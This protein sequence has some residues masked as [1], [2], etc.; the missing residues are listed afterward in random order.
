MP[1]PRRGKDQHR[2]RGTR[3]DAQPQSKPVVRRR[4]RVQCRVAAHRH[5]PPD[6]HRPTDP[7]HEE[8]QAD[9]NRD[10]GDGESRQAAHHHMAELVG[11]DLHEQ[12]RGQQADADRGRRQVGRSRR[13]QRDARDEAVERAG[14]EHQ[15]RVRLMLRQTGTTQ[16][17]RTVE[18]RRQGCS[19]RDPRATTQTAHHDRGIQAVERDRY[20]ILL[21]ED[22][23]T[24]S[25]QRPEQARD[26]Q[27]ADD[28]ADPPDPCPAPSTRRT[29]LGA[30][31]L[32]LAGPGRRRQPLRELARGH[33]ARRFQSAEQR[34]TRDVDRH[35]RWLTGQAACRVVIARFRHRDHDPT[36][37]HKP[38]RRHHHHQHANTERDQLRPRD[39]PHP[40][41]RPDHDALPPDRA[42]PTKAI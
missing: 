24:P 8:P 21:D 36:R 16:R 10:L 28:Q 20:P 4:R 1:P 25:P 39:R 23:R 22:T 7:P 29:R 18:T 17:R 27:P 37:I 34:G 38:D 33:V 9:P 30:G 26:S 2:H 6:D 14:Q 42:R 11:H 12:Q 5:G 41:T 31:V 40:P 35:G 15:P 32:V 3:R 13:R 19:C